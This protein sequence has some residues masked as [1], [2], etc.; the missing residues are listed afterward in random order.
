MYKL[1]GRS[2]NFTSNI[3]YEHLINFH[4]PWNFP[5]GIKGFRSYLICL[6]SFNIRPTISWWARK[7]SWCSGTSDLPFHSTLHSF[8]VLKNNRFSHI[9]RVF[10]TKRKNQGF[11]GDNRA[12]S[13]VY[14]QHH[15]WNNYNFV[16]TQ[17][18][19][20]FH[21]LT[22]YIPWQVIW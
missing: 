7:E 14:C 6:Y 18:D 22:I 8:F 19:I 15:F 12:N 21:H 10:P 5:D 11:L 20:Y 3:K 17:N 9:S 13:W 16:T 1:K 4:S 2:P